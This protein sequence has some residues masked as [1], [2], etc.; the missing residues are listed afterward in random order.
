MPDEPTAQAPESDSPAHALRDNPSPPPARHKRLGLKEVLIPLVLAILAVVL[1][2]LTFV[3]YPRRANISPPAFSQL[4]IT[5]DVPI[6]YIE[7]GVGQASPA[8]AKMNIF[9]AL[10]RGIPAAAATLEV[11]LPIGATFANCHPP[12]C[13]V[14]RVG[15]LETSSWTERLAFKP[16]GSS[17]G[18]TADFL[19]NADNFGATSNGL[20]ALASIPEV[21]YTTTYGTTYQGIE[22]PPPQ[23]QAGY[24][25]PSASSYDFSSSFPT[26]YTTK[27][28]AVWE[29]TVL[30]GDTAQRPAVGTN[31]AAQTSDEVSTFIAGALVAL[32][33]AAILAAVIEAVHTRDWETLRE[34]RSK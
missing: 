34:L 16:T 25:L 14:S 28:A 2:L 5:T 15:H 3:V 20:T 26:T 7:Y 8:T 30:P 13:A 23:L 17:L 19:V 11:Y 29:E 32:A 1:L 12:A 4:I 18:A 22:Y 33:G 9:V 10:P 27:S 21:T 6:N 31:H 24:R